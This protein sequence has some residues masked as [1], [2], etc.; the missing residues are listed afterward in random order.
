M[1]S[2]GRWLPPRKSPAWPGTT[3]APSGIVPARTSARTAGQS[4][5]CSIVVNAADRRKT[6]NA[7]EAAHA[8]HCRAE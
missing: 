8:C 1:G 6:W 2:G 3:T 4:C 5:S 7:S